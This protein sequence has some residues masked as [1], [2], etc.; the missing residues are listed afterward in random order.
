V[1]YVLGVYAPVSETPPENLVVLTSSLPTAYEGVAYSVTLQ[2]TGG[3]GAV[4]WSIVAGEA[5]LNALG[6]ALVGDTITGT[7]TSTGSVGLTIRATDSA[8]P[9]PDTADSGSIT[10]TVEA[11]PSGLTVTTTSLPS[12]TRGQPFSVTLQASGGTLPYT[13]SRVAPNDTLP[14]GITQ[15]NADVSGTPTVAGTSP[16]EFRVTDAAA[17]AADSGVLNLT[18][19]QVADLQITTVS[20]TP[21]V[22]GAA[23]ASVVQASGGYG[24]RTWSVLSGALPSWASLNASSGAITGTPD[25]AAVTTFTLHVTDTEGRTDVREF[26][27]TVLEPSTTDHGYFEALAD[28]PECVASWTLR[29][30]SQLD[31]LQNVTTQGPSTFYTYDPDNDTFPDAQDAA[32]LFIPEGTVSLVPNAKSLK[33]PVPLVASTTGT[34]LLVVDFY[35]DA[36]F[37]TGRNVGTHPSPITGAKGVRLYA[38]GSNHCAQMFNF[39]YALD[40]EVAKITHE[41]STDY[42]PAGMYAKERV[43]PSGTNAFPQGTGTPA[44]QPWAEAYGV[45][46]NVWHRFI[47][48]IR[49]RQPAS[50]FTD[51]NATYGV[52]VLNDNGRDADGYWNMQTCWIMREGD[53]VP[54]RLLYQVPMSWYT[55][56]PFLSSFYLNFDTSQTAPTTEDMVGYFRN[57]VVLE[58][59][60]LTEADAFIFQAPTR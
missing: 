11:V 22:N 42:L 35:L 30:Q 27:L 19:D 46:A 12:V 28:L 45:L 31:S 20:L 5:A 10:L 3:T 54:S 4:T 26:S 29:S 43:R 17:A 60:A 48:E 59:Y 49:Y 13:W 33:F 21:G 7:P 34:Q 57:F 40:G 37:Q 38:G 1:S 56:G 41:F 23:Y 2:S 15:D 39:Q 9:T 32:K 58:D 8:T 6:L 36:S 24:A 47:W 44:G 55:K 18:V 16:L 14:A 50:A 53:T 52:T 51:W 25:A